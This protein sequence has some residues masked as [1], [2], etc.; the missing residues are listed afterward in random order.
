[1]ELVRTKLQQLGNALEELWKDY[2]Q[3]SMATVVELMVRSILLN[4]KNSTNRICT[5]QEP[6]SHDL[7]LLKKQQRSKMKHS[8]MRSRTTMTSTLTIYT[9]WSFLQ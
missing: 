6:L 3:K 7:E 1:M 4:G 5:I 8:T 2:W 9:K